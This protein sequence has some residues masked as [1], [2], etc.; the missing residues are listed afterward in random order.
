MTSSGILGFTRRKERKS[1]LRMLS[2]KSGDLILDAGCGSG[3]YSI[4][5]KELGANV[6]GIDVS[7]GMAAAARA[8]GVDAIAADLASMSLRA[9]FDKI[10]CAGVLEFCEDP[11]GIV[12]NL[13]SH[14]KEDGHLVLL[15]PKRSPLGILYK[16]YHLSHG[17]KVNLFSME[18]V[19]NIIEEAGLKAISKEEPTWMSLVLK[20]AK[21]VV[22]IERMPD[23]GPAQ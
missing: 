20:C 11:M 22:D 13:C 16:L 5:M 12:E 3:F 14:L 1:V 10:L 21:G 6:L 8:C 4:P 9:K 17:L 7:A 2:P 18:D 19:E 23:Q 15:A